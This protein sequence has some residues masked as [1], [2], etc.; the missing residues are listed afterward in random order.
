MRNVAK[1][2][3]GVIQNAR[4][5]VPRLFKTTLAPINDAAASMRTGIALAERSELR[6][7]RDLDDDGEPSPAT[8]A[9]APVARLRVQRAALDLQ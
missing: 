2:E 1:A 9:R 3:L 7:F 5:D 8:P 4:L 6:H